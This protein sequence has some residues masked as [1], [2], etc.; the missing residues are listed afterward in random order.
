MA[1]AFDAAVDG[2]IVIPG[3]SLTWAHTC[4]GSDRILLVAAFDDSGGASLITGVTYNSVALTKI[5]EVQVLDNRWV[6][7]WYLVAPATGSNNVVITA[8]A[9]TVIAGISGSYT[10]A[11]QTGQPDSFATNTSTASTSLTTTTTVVASDCWLVMGIKSLG[12]NSY[13]YS[14]TGSERISNSQMHFWDSNATIGTGSQAVVA[15]ASPDNHGAVLVS[16]APVGG[17][18]AGHPTMRRWGG[19]PAVGGQGVNDAGTG[20]GKMWGRSRS[21]RIVIPRWL[22]DQERQAA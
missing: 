9:S 2:S 10:G 1:L 16:I 4:T 21:G 14:P 18:A 6:T 17:G 3:T 5:A 7:L 13:S 8:S 12:V 15:T 11:A 20:G 22:Q 19:T